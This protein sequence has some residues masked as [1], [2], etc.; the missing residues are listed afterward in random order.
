MELV[1]LGNGAAFA[2]PDQACSG[3]LVRDGD[4]GLLMD[5]GN[6]VV[7]RLYQVREQDHLTGLIFSHLHAD[8]LLDIFSLF[9]SRVYAVGRSYPRL[10]LYLPPGEGSRLSSLAEVLRVEPAKLLEQA[11]EPVEFDPGAGLILGDL[12]I[13]FA[14]NDHPIRTFAMRVEGADGSV[15]YSSDTGPQARL[16]ELAR[17]CDLLLAEAT[18]TEDAY[19]PSRPIHLTP[20]LAAEAAARAGAKRLLL[21]HIWHGYDRAA[22]LAEARRVFPRTELAEELRRY[23]IGR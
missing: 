6:G 8:H 18:W 3:Y 9:Y 16:E 10:P 11:F 21:T 15:V 22:M 23:P 20:R 2:G 5:C 14:E 17:G 7:S 1:V 4:T 19:D 12:R 13:T